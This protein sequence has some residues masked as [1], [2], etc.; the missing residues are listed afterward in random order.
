[1]K[2]AVIFDLDGTLID[3][4]VGICNC[5]KYA[6]SKLS[7]APLCE[8]QYLEFIGPPP[9]ETYQRLYGLSLEQSFQATEF[10]R[11]YGKIKGIYEATVYDG[12]IELL[13]ELKN[14]NCKLG[15]ATYK[16]Q[17]LADLILAHFN[18]AKYFDS[19]CGADS[20]NKLTKKDII[21]LCIDNLSAKKDD[22]I[23]I[24]DSEYDAIAAQKIGVDFIGLTYGYGFKNNDKVAEFK[25]IGCANDVFGLFNLMKGNNNEY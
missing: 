25:S 21:E 23:Y 17:D 5:V 6:E 16:R 4:S 2:K 1:M 15:V 18:I 3:T 12:I 20:D 19:I 11:E 8:E 22:V 14:N 9:Y 24:G 10:H 13:A 7:L